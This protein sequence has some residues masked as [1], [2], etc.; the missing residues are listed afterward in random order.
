[1]E[2]LIMKI[3]NYIINHKKSHLY[4]KWIDLVANKDAV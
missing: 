4:S 3:I 2:V 1:M